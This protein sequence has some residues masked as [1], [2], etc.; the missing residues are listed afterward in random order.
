MSAHAASQGATL[1]QHVVA[2]PPRAAASVI[3]LRDTTQGLEA[4][5]LERPQAASVMAGVWVF[6][7]GKVDGED[8]QAGRLENE[9][10]TL[11]CAES[12]KARFIHQPFDLVQTAAFMRAALR[13]TEEECAVRVPVDA[14]EGWS[15]WITPKIPS[16]STKRFDTVF[17]V[18]ALPPG[19]EARHDGEE[20][21][22]GQWVMPL[23]ALERYWKQE[24]M[25]APPQIMSLV[26]RSTRPR[27]VVSWPIPA[28]KRIR[29]IRRRSRDL[30]G[31][32]GEAV[33]SNRLAAVLMVFLPGLGSGNAASVRSSVGRVA[34]IGG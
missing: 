29:W 7:G 11:R 1:N 18:A 13:E 31:W 27:V 12:L 33:V 16:M 17:F 9:Q 6:P 3:L 26:S 5:L 14:I 4:F 24:I 8:Q 2:E 15:R 20:S 23:Q 34:S 25:L 22:Q 10:M 30:P 19:E 32:F 21:V 28:T